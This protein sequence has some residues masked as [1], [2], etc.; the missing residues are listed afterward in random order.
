MA[1]G[2]GRWRVI[3]RKFFC[4]D[5]KSSGVHYVWK[6]NKLGQIGSFQVVS[7]MSDGEFPKGL[8]SCQSIFAFLLFLKKSVILYHKLRNILIANRISSSPHSSLI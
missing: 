7:N 5:F 6:L 2:R 4:P 1:P 8:K 3:K